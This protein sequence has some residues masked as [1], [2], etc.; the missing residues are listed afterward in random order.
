MVKIW[1][2]DFAVWWLGHVSNVDLM[3]STYVA[4][5]KFSLCYLNCNLLSNFLWFYKYNSVDLNDSPPP[6]MESIDSV[7]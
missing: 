3:F 6:K 1:M 2:D 5:W 4:G 7:Y